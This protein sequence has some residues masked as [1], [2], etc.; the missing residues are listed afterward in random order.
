MPIRLPMTSPALSGEIRSLSSSHC[1]MHRDNDIEAIR[2]QG[3]RPGDS[4]R[5]ASAE[6]GGLCHALASEPRSWALPRRGPLC[7]GSA[8]WASPPPWSWSPSVGCC[9]WHHSPAPVSQSVQGTP[10]PLSSAVST[11]LCPSSFAPCPL[12]ERSTHHSLRVRDV[13]HGVGR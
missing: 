8:A 4:G 9:S 7:C 6:G 3:L 12:P 10:S 5:L 13:E 2:R 1:E 11:W